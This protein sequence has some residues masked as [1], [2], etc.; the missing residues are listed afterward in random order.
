MFRTKYMPFSILLSTVFLL[1]CPKQGGAPGEG[2][3]HDR[4]LEFVQ[5][6]KALEMV[7]RKT[8]KIDYE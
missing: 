4:H 3:N 7:D 2:D 8:G 6:I 5:R 1:G